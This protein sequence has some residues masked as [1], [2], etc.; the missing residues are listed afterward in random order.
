[1]KLSYGS[2]RSAWDAHSNGIWVSLLRVIGSP[3]E[4]YRCHSDGQLSRGNFVTLRIFTDQ[5]IYGLGDA[6]LNAGN[7]P[8]RPTL[9]G[10]LIPCLIGREP[11]QTEDSWRYF[12][13]SAGGAA[14]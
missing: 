12:Y 7:S 8:S 3:R 10:H 6:T 4:N 2:N 14:R 9:Q 13:R 11:F 1:V 5:G